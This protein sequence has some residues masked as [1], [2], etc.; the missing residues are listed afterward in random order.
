MAIEKMMKNDE[1]PGSLMENTLVMKVVPQFG[2]AFSA[3]NSHFTMI[4]CRHNY[5]IHGVY[6]PTNITGGHHPVE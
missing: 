3:N 1:L 6:K 5:S 2:I 4:Y